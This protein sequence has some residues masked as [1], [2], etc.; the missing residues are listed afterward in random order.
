VA[1]I[2]QV[3]TQGFTLRAELRD[4]L[5]DLY[6]CLKKDSNIIFHSII[7]EEIGPMDKVPK[8]KREVPLGMQVV[9]KKRVAVN[10]GINDGVIGVFELGPSEKM[11]EVETP[12]S[13]TGSVLFVEKRRSTPILNEYGSI[14][15]IPLT[16]DLLKAD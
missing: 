8:E 14:V 7:S 5:I 2:L 15:D 6:A 10:S 1:R 11:Y 13:S 12:E 16:Q 4:K 9:R 3:K